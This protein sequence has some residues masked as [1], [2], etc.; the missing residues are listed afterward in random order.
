[1][2]VKMS[3]LLEPGEHLGYWL[4]KERYLGSWGVVY[5]ICKDHGDP[6]DP[7][8][9]EMIAKTLRPELL[10]DERKVA[11]FERE[12]YTWL[13]LASYKH[14]VRLY[15]VDRFN[16]QPYALGEYIPAL[17]FPNT[18]RQWMEHGLIEKELALRFGI[19]IVYAISYARAH[20]VDIHQDLKPENVMITPQ[21]V[22]KVTDWGLSRIIPREKETVKAF[23]AMPYQNRDAHFDSTNTYGSSGYAPPELY[24]EL[25][26]P[27][28][29][30]DVFSIAV[31][32]GEML[33]GE[34]FA[35]DT[36]ISNLKYILEG[37]SA[38]TEK[39]FTSILSACLA[40]K[41]EK[42]PDDLGEIKEIIGLAFKD[43]TGIS[44]ESEP[45]PDF[46]TSSDRGQRAYALGMLGKLDETLQE[47]KQL[48]AHQQV[49]PKQ[50]AKTKHK[51]SENQTPV[52]MMD[53]KE[54]GFV[55][56]IP[57]TQIDDAKKNLKDNPDNFENVKSL[58]GMYS[59][60]ADYEKASELF[61]KYLKNNPDHLE[62]L[63]QLVYLLMQS[64]NFTDALTYSKK[65][66][67]LKPSDAKVWLKQCEC[68]EQVGKITDA[69]QSA[70]KAVTAE[71]E[72]AEAHLKMGHYLSQSERFPE[73]KKEFED[74]IKYDH[75]N[76]V[77]WFNLATVD[78]KTNEVEDAIAHFQ[79]AIEIDPEMYQA[80]N[81]LGVIHMQL[82]LLQDALGYFEKAIA[83]QPN[84]AR[85]WF[86]KGQIYQVLGKKDLAKKSFEK[87]LEIDPSHALAQQ[88]L[89]KLK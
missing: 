42:R 79:K 54:K 18:L 10:H 14:I 3:K 45:H 58:A 89:Q 63:D 77:A 8:P 7:R 25:A 53:L 56:I 26:A 62:S 37:V 33:S 75:K 29:K 47:H 22:A 83:I 78:L 82:S 30:A 28:P 16:G 50:K 76:A 51:K 20:D 59:L 71:P 32:L 61:E 70:Q 73:A 5:R 9:D 65:Y 46:L 57:A 72:N 55:A 68:Y 6:N 52:V 64:R 86:N 81:T 87:A 40:G 19:H 69:L 15:T 27:T 12:C 66:L 21:G 74:S 11:R 60:S 39:Q 41:P 4:I 2:E 13:S 31:M 34:R 43:F 17:Y 49:E 84:Y 35:A 80:M 67:K 24:D 36:P 1:M 85:P 44:I 88:A 23:S 38:K 48:L